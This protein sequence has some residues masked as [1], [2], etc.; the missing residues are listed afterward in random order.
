LKSVYVIAKDSI[1]DFSEAAYSVK[2]AIVSQA[3]IIHEDED[4]LVVHQPGRS[5]FTLITFASI[6]DRPDGNW[7]WG[8]ATASKLDLDS[9]GIVAKANHRYP[10]SFMARL[11]PAINAHAQPIRIGY[12]FSMGAY[13][14]LKNGGLLGL[15]HVLA[16]SP[17][18]Y[19]LTSADMRKI[20]WDGRFCPERNDGPLLACQELAPIN[21]QVLDPFFSLDWEQGEFFASAGR[22]RTIRTP[23]TQHFTVGL[24][25]GTDNLQTTIKLLL[26]QDFDGISTFLNKNRR[27]AQ[28]RASNLARASLA[29]GN[30]KRASS[31]WQ[32]ALDKGVK[33]EAIERA[34]VSGL[35]ESGR[36]Y[37][38]SRSETEIQGAVAFID[39]ISLESPD[40]L[41]LQRELG[42]WCM[43]YCT[44]QAAL[45][46]LRRAVGIA[47]NDVSCWVALGHA[48]HGSGQTKEALRTLQEARDICGDHE[49]ITALISRFTPESLLLIAESRWNLMKRLRLK[50]WVIKIVSIVKKAKLVPRR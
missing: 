31:L 17:V 10:R 9:I 35:V 37:L 8:K 19:A 18:N 20:I 28:E 4:C 7:F 5:D 22:I 43:V 32:K 12:G 6:G 30:Q 2:F 39:K 40:S 14:A 27:T 36:R 11:V 48:L 42:H 23:F 38:S 44:P 41:R 15:T 46:P 34:R 29:R 13:G 25:R 33:S 21:L 49:N 50:V 3:R 47:P 26:D 16:L 24:L 1:I 45:G